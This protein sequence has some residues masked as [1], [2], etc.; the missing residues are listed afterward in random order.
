MRYAVK[1]NTVTI[2]K[3]TLALKS[4]NCTCVTFENTGDESLTI[5]DGITVP[6]G[7]S[8][9]FENLP[10]EYIAQPFKIIF[11]GG[12]AAPSCLVIKKFVTPEK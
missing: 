8:F 6:A 1:Y 7:S 2:N 11:A 5:M 10:N 3:S 12:G 4:E 9:V